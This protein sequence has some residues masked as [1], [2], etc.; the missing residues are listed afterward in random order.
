MSPAQAAWDARPPA[1]G[2]HRADRTERTAPNGPHRTDRTVRPGR[3][4]PL[5]ALA[6]TRVRRRR[7]RRALGSAPLSSLPLRS[8]PCHLLFP[9]VSSSVRPLLLRGPSPAVG[10]CPAACGPPPRRLLTEFR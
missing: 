1:P 2:P 4:S 10:C 7:G 9:A 5:L 8:A 6:R 3:T